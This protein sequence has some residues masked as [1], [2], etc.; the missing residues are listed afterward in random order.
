[1]TSLCSRMCT[2]TN[3]GFVYQSDLLREQHS[4][5]FGFLLFFPTQLIIQALLL[6]GPV[7]LDSDLTMFA[8]NLTMCL[9]LKMTGRGIS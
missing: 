3:G 9:G 7:A 4:F 5:H 8:G 2:W 1:M 6:P